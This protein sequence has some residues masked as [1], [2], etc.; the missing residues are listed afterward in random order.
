MTIYTI[1]PVEGTETTASD[2]GTGN[3]SLCRHPNGKD[4][5]NQS[6]DWKNCATATPGAGNQL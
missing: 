3:G 5:D 2:Q 6:V 1:N 4:T